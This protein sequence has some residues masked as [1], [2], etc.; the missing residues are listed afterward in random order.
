MRVVIG[1]GE[2][3][4][5]A[6]TASTAGTAITALTLA[7]DSLCIGFENTTD[8]QLIVAIDGVQKKRV[9]AGSYRVLD[10]GANNGSFA[11]GTVVAVFRS[12]AGAP[13]SGVFEVTSVQP[14]LV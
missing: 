11:K 6:I 12:A 14:S 7:Y 13:A 5:T 1:V 2:L 10:L 9:P 3:D 8:V 4:Y